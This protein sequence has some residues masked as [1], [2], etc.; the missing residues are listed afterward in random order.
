MF[1]IIFW[2]ILLL[3]L[4]YFGIFHSTLLF[5]NT[6]QKQNHD[7]FVILNYSDLKSPD[8]IRAISLKYIL[9]WE[10]SQEDWK[11]DKGKEKFAKYQKYNENHFRETEMS[12]KFSQSKDNQNSSFTTDI[13]SPHYL[14]ESRDYSYISIYGSFSHLLAAADEQ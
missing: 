11:L 13:R 8:S 2:I 5:S 6:F 1:R 12:R 10:I 4:A 3:I 14:K 9:T 7:P